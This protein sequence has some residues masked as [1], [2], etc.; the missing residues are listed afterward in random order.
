MTCILLLCAAC[1]GAATTR[2]AGGSGGVGEERKLA[3]LET[4][5]SRT[6]SKMSRRAGVEMAV[7][8]LIGTRR[9]ELQAEVLRSEAQFERG[10][11]YRTSL[12]RD[13]AALFVF[14]KEE[15]Q[16]FWMKNVSIPLDIVFA[17]GERRVVG[18]VHD[19]T[20]YSSSDLSVGRPSRY[21]VEMNAGLARDYGIAEGARM[22]IQLDRASCNCE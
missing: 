17:D 15:E 4:P 13:A 16:F 8:T 6:E 3:A 2:S 11:M 12:A 22:E 10:L 7:V 1:G 20:P 21:V 14:P 19:A 5:K 9:L 18:V